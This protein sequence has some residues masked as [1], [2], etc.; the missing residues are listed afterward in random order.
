M[1]RTILDPVNAFTALT[2]NSTT[3][4]AAYAV[5]GDAYCDAGKWAEFT[6]FLTVHSVAGTS[7]PKI[8]FKIQHSPDPDADYDNWVNLTAAVDATTALTT[9]SVA[10]PDGTIMSFGRYV[11]VVAQVAGTSPVLVA[12]GYFAPKE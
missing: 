2:F 10:V 9:Y 4:G 8:Q 5:V 6:F 11:R 1:S 3:P 12:S 7:T